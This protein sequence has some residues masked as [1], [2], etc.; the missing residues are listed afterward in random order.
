MTDITDVSSSPAVFD[1][2]FPEAMKAVPKDGRHDFIGR[3]ADTPA[4]H[5]PFLIFM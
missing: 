3:A 4:R 1:F 2:P 5:R